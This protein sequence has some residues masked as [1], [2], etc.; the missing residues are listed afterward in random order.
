LFAPKPNIIFVYRDQYF[1]SFTRTG[2][3]TSLILDEGTVFE[4]PEY[5]LTIV[6]TAWRALSVSF[7]S[8]GYSASIHVRTKFR[9]LLTLKK[10]PK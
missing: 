2:E 8:V 9:P 1:F 6:K 3:E 10:K 5:S 7:G 4:F